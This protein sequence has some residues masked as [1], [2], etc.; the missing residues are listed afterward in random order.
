[1]KPTRW[2]LLSL[3]ALTVL[4]LS[5]AAATTN[6]TFRTTGLFYTFTNNSATATLLAGH[7]LVNLAMGRA[8]TDQSKPNQVLALT[9]PCDYSFA[10]LVVYD[11]TAAHIIAT[12]ASAGDLDALVQTVTNQDDRVRFLAQFQINPTGSAANGLRGGYLTVAGRIHANRTNGCPEAVALKFDHDRQDHNFG[13]AD[14]PRSIDPDTEPL[15]K[16]TGLAHCVGVL[17]VVQVGRTNTLLIPFGH[18][19]IRGVQP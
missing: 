6:Q 10:N 17:D 13:D 19:S 2:I 16:R 9:L 5:A 15:T 18:L 7:Q 11:Q 14:V 1:M 4:H 8:P 12:I 3:T